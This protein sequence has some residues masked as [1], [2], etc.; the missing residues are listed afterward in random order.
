MYAPEA[1][2]LIGKA[3]RVFRQVYI[4]PA[5]LK[6]RKRD[7]RNVKI[8]PQIM[9]TF[10]MPALGEAFL[11]EGGP[12]RS[13]SNSRVFRITIPAIIRAREKEMSNSSPT[14]QI[15]WVS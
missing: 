15:V 5:R 1:L 13:W 7:A 2:I 14:L 4:S 8:A 10:P 9:S 11:E 6:P 12:L 3:Q